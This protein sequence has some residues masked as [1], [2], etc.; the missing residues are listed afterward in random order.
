ML[1]AEKIVQEAHIQTIHGGVSLTIG[2]VR[3]SYWIPKLW[4][5]AKKI[6]NNCFGCKRFQITAFA[7]PPLGAL[8]LNR[9]FGNRAFQVIGVDYARPLYYRIS[10]TKEGKA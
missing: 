4:G 8:L 3:K 1:L 9:T 5:L 10:Q 2:E 6:R 7:N